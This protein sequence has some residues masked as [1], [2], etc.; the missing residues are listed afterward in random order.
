MD[1]NNFF[2][3]SIVFQTLFIPVLQAKQKNGKLYY[4]I[5]EYREFLDNLDIGITV[6]EDTPSGY[7]FGAIYLVT[8]SKK[9]FLAKIKYG[10]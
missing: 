9:W 6:T 5:N 7:S 2:T 4:H 8:D 1:S 10:I 3:S